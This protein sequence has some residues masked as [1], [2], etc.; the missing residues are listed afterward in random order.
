MFHYVLS[1]RV[2][3]VP[4]QPP[5]KKTPFFQG[6]PSPWKNQDATGFTPTHL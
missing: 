3:D 1:P 5:M 4:M 2:D 6:I